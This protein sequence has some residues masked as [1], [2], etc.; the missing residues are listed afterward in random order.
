MPSFDSGSSTG[1]Q[2]SSPNNTRPS[3]HSTSADREQ[4]VAR[5]VRCRHPRARS[6]SAPRRRP[7]R[8]TPA[9][10]RR[11]PGLRRSWRSMIRRWMQRHRG[12]VRGTRRGVARPARGPR[13][14]DRVGARR[15]GAAGVGHRR[16]RVRRRPAPPVSAPAGGRPRRRVA[17]W[18]R[19]ARDEA[20]DVPGRSRPISRRCR[21]GAARSAARGRARATSTCPTTGCR[22]R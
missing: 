13:F 20:P 6:T 15:G 7:A 3:A 12:G 8:R 18:S 4:L 22:G 11:P 14:L 17:R 21:S 5:R 10:R 2:R 1:T 16:P 9:G 19:L